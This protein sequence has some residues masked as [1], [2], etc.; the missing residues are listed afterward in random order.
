MTYLALNCHFY[1][2]LF[3][4]LHDPS[5]FKCPLSTNALCSVLSQ[6]N[7]QGAVA[8]YAKSK[9]SNPLTVEGGTSKVPHLLE[10]LLEVDV[11]QGKESHSPRDVATG[12]LPMSQW[13]AHTHLHVGSTN[14]P[15]GVIK[16]K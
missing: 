1:P 11:C 15:Q 2:N 14:W 12:R 13:M 9:Y 8:I 6:T 16:N 3:L 7:S 4:L 10:N 5:L